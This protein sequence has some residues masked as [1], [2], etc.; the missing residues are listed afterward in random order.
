M[1]A[2][3]GLLFLDRGCRLLRMLIIHL[4]LKDTDSGMDGIPF[5]LG[6]Y[7]R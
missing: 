5:F 6:V 4:K 1:I 7:L 2:S 3:I